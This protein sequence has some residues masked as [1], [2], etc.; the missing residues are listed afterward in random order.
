MTALTLLVSTGGNSPDLDAL[1]RVFAA[2]P[3]R[4]P[5]AGYDRLGRVLAGV[6]DGDGITRQDGLLVAVEGRIDNA[7]EL[8]R[9]LGLSGVPDSSA[10][11]VALWHRHGLR[12]P[13]LLRGRCA[14]AVTD[15]RTTWVW[16]DHLGFAPLFYG[17][18]G[19]RVAVATEA[20][21][22]AA[23]LG[24]AVEPDLSVVESTLWGDYD[25]DTPA[26]VKGVRRL[27]KA[28]LLTIRGTSTATSSYWQ[29]EA[30]LERSRGR[31][32]EL[33]P[34]A[35]K[36]RFDALMGTACERALGGDDVL[37]LSGGI[38]SPA[39]AAYAAQPHLARTGRPL[40]AVV[41][42]YPDH[43]S[44]DESGWARLVA[45]DLGLKLETFEH[46]RAAPSGPVEHRVGALRDW[47]GLFDGPGPLTAIAELDD[48]YRDLRERGF[49]TVLTGEMAEFVLDLRAGAVAHLLGAGQVAAAARLLAAQRAAGIRWRWLAQQVLTT[50]IPPAVARRISGSS[51][52]TPAW[53]TSERAVPPGWG[54][55]PRYRW[56][57]NQL[58]AFDG[59]GLSIEAE[60]VVQAKHGIT[61]RRPFADVDL[62]EFFLALPAEV[63]VPGPARKQLLRSLLRGRV[64]DAILDRKDKT[65]FNDAVMDSVDWPVLDHVLSRVE[66]RF[67][68][69]NYDTLLQ[70]IA[71][72]DLDVSGSLWAQRLTMAHLFVEGA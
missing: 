15:G 58:G 4:G 25:D 22:V 51:R 8:A 63:K 69:I 17:T 7:G 43:P 67:E 55:A 18:S 13:E 2:S 49:R 52:R 42:V 21:Q 41:V 71:A 1:P 46:R 59:P 37:S 9:G 39:V 72:R 45:D 19:G 36:E 57:T 14:V 3:H 24:L 31:R 61:V 34:A 32:A 48:N 62:W 54:V 11:V 66:H 28:T 33:H 50:P 20:K 64:P 47:V 29:P 60:D 65:V 23:G 30:I 5:L 53:V 68:G 16:R 38:D 70:H 40:E 44:V 27:P 35:L 56:R 6:S 26:A 10:L 12:T